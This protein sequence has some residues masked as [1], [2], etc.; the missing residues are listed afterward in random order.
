MVASSWR[1]GEQVMALFVACQLL[2]RV[3]ERVT[4][5]P[6]SVHHSQLILRTGWCLFALAPAEVCHVRLETRICVRFCVYSG[7]AGDP[8]CGCVGTC[9]TAVTCW[10]RLPLALDT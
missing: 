8:V 7:S 10:Q 5:A 9:G 4:L 6:R 2:L 1:S 3:F